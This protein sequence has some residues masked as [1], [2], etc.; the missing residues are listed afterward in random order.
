M[1]ITNMQ[2]VVRTP[3]P[4]RR[5]WGLFVDAATEL[6]ATELSERGT[7]RI[8]AG[9]TWMPWSCD[10]ILRGDIDCDHDGLVNEL[11]VGWQYEG[12][13]TAMRSF[14]EVATQAPFKL[15]DGLRCG[16]LSYSDDELY[17]RLRARARA[18]TSSV[19]ARELIDGA[20][21]GGVSLSGTAGALV[22]PFPGPDGAFAAIEAHLAE[23]LHGAQGIVHIPPAVLHV[24][25]EHG[26][27]HQTGDSLYTTTGHRVAADA[28]NDGSFGPAAG[29]A[30]SYWIY[31]TGPVLY[32]VT[33][34]FFLGDGL[35]PFVNIVERF[36]EAMAILVFDP[37]AVAAVELDMA[38]AAP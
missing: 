30:S 5:P 7:N 3:G 19:L 26:Y 2:K 15:V 36:A 11:N 12:K 23:T 31:A 33:D 22:A 14:P 34:P 28:G 18:L 8:G 24:A 37:C 17:D 29:G 25:K 16:T 38:P 6:T 13:D 20:A 32:H 35:D 10:P 4:A 1:P 27:I 21:S 9:A